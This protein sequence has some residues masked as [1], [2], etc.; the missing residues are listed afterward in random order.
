MNKETDKLLASISCVDLSILN[1]TVLDK[2]NKK[3]S[4]LD[5]LK[6]LASMLCENKELLEAIVVI[7]H[8]L[9]VSI[10]KDCKKTQSRIYMNFQLSWHQ[11]CSAFLLGSEH[12][13]PVIKLQ[14]SDECTP[15][16]TRHM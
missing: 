10:Y 16:K 11:H 9:F 1:A 4:I 6:H 7:H 2:L 13:L 12:S 8:D 3:L 15:G 14:E 5:R